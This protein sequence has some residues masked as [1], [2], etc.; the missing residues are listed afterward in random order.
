MAADGTAKAGKQACRPAELLSPAGDMERLRMA[1]AY[2]ADA[3]YLSGPRFG[4]RAAAGNFSD[5]ELT[6]AVLCCHDRGVRVYAACNALLR[7][8]DLK[9]LPPYLEF[10]ETTGVDAVILTDL[11]AFALAAKHAPGLPRHVSTQAGVMNA[12]A[13]RAFYDMGASRIILAREL[14]LSEIAELPGRDTCGAG[15]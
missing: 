2:G 10:L 14:T 3:V 5:G 7:G 4:L 13:A 6:E 1:L 9:A 12:A 11:G 15:A 8:D